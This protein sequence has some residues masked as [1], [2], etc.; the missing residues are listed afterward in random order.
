ME[1]KVVVWMLPSLLLVIVWAVL[2]F[3]IH[4]YLLFLFE[5]LYLDSILVL[6]DPHNTW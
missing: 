5:R 6:E 4:L 1:V 3:L 2:L